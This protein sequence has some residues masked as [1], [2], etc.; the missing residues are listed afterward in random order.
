MA[1]TLYLASAKTLKRDTGAYPPLV[2]GDDSGCYWFLYRYFEAAN[3]ERHKGE[4]IDLYGGG[5]AIEGY[6]L[7]RLITELEQA[8]IDT[9]LKPDTWRVLVG[10]TGPTVGV[11][12]EDW[13][14]VTRADVLSTISS[15]LALARCASDSLKLVC[16]GD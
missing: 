11:E 6:Q 2:L 10:W 3:L 12:T 1:A 9:Q 16:C 15:L 7:H 13:R 5:Q 8:L 4:L 14:T